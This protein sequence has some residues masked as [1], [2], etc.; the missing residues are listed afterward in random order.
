MHIF[1]PNNTFPTLILINLTL[2]HL[3]NNESFENIFFFSI[4]IIIHNPQQI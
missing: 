3:I 1:N 4:F 2:L